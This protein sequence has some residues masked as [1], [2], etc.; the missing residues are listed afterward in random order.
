MRPKR[1]TLA[2]RYLIAKAGVVALLSLAV[3]RIPAFDEPITIA[4]TAIL[5]IPSAFY[6]GLKTGIKNIY[7][8]VIGALVGTILIVTL[9]NDF[10]A[11]PPGIMIVCLA[12]YV[13]NWLDH[14]PL[15]AFTLLVVS[16]YPEE[17]I[18]A[19]SLDRTVQVGA[20]IG[21]A[22]LVNWAAS[23]F[24]YRE[25]YLGRCR[26]LL[27]IAADCFERLQRSFIAGDADGMERLEA[28]FHGL[29]R[30]IGSAIDEMADLKKELR[31]RK[32]S[33]G[34]S[35]AAVVSLSRI[36][37]RLASVAHYSWDVLWFSPRIFR[38]GLLTAGQK[39]ALDAEI[40]AAAACFRGI[41]DSC[42]ALG[43]PA[44]GGSGRCL[45]G[46]AADGPVAAAG[47]DSPGE[48]DLCVSSLRMSVGHLRRETAE[49]AEIVRT[50]REEASA[51]GAGNSA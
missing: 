13:L 45:T 8:T 49:L 48:E 16:Y 3:S 43:T 15:A 51:R 34:L 36:A 46:P 39:Q 33:G 41:L 35:Y 17:S 1:I 4:F 32:E 42:S 5:C 7:A 14:F 29:F 10:L 28:R 12:C 30:L 18:W 50:L 11:I 44:R 21:I 22:M 19:S 47:L 6:R 38:D 37:D 27:G 26:E 40:D 9:D 20:G 31:L 23:R 24:R 25:L 2:A